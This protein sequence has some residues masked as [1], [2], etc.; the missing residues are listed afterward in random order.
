ML[1]RHTWPINAPSIRR[2]LA[3]I[4]AL[5]FVVAAASLG[6]I[7]SFFPQPT[8]AADY[9]W[10]IQRELAVQC[11]FTSRAQCMET[12]SGTTS[13]CIENPRLIARSLPQSVYGKLDHRRSK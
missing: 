13:E 11:D 5:P 8:L 12:A 10:C 6:G 9:A 4:R 3:R 2:T 7:I 1:K